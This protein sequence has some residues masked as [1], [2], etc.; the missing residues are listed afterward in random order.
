MLEV[1]RCRLT[2]N[3]CGCSWD[4][5]GDL[6]L[7]DTECNARNMGT[8]T[9]YT[10]DYHASCP[11]CGTPVDVTIDAWEYPEGAFNSKDCR[12]SEGFSCDDD[13]EVV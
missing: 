7:I 6:T 1:K 2:C 13:V 5:A 4:I 12:V 10:W 11:K 8:E 9:Q 3:K